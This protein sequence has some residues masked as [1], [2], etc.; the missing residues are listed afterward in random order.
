MRAV[1]LHEQGMRA[2]S[3]PA[4][5]LQLHGRLGWAA[6][7]CCRS[8]E[9]WVCLV[10]GMASEAP[11]W[12]SGGD[13][14]RTDSCLT[15]LNP[16]PRCRAACDESAPVAKAGDNERTDRLLAAEQ[17]VLDAGGCVVRLVGLYHAQR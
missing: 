6:A 13:T 9:Q 17:A 11:R 12:P 14:A 10:A 4:V 7:A 3:K 16:V 15:L 8:C 1:G 2:W 5:F